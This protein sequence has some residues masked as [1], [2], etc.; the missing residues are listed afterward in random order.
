MRFHHAIAVQGPFEFN[1]I[2]T[3]AFRHLEKFQ[4][5]CAKA[6]EKSSNSFHQIFQMEE[7]I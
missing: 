2:T 3:L 6:L 5:A 7:P 1:H 4:I